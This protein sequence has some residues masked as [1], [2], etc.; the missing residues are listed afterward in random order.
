MP[1]Y[2]VCSQSIKEM[3]IEVGSGNENESSVVALCVFKEEIK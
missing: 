1:S 3:R 2:E